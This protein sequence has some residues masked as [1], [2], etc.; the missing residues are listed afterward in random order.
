M[1]KEGHVNLSGVQVTYK[2]PNDE[3]TY[4][5]GK[6]TTADRPYFELYAVLEQG[7]C[8]MYSDS[9]VVEGSIKCP[10]GVTHDFS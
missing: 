10:C 1:A 9:A 7:C 4:T 3:Q 6:W 2:C 5:V 8:D